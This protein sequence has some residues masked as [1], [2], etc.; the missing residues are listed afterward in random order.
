VPEP[1][2]LTNQMCGADRSLYLR[3]GPE[4]RTSANS[5]RS[6][7]DH[8]RHGCVHLQLRMISLT[9]IP[10]GARPAHG[11]SPATISGAAGLPGY[12]EPCIA[13]EENQFKRPRVRTG[14][15]YRTSG[16]RRSL[17]FAAEIGWVR[18]L[19]KAQIQTNPLRGFRSLC[20]PA[21][22]RSHHHL[23]ATE[24]RGGVS[25]ACLLT[26]LSLIAKRPTPIRLAHPRIA[27]LNSSTRIVPSN[28]SPTLD[29]LLQRSR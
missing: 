17:A 12:A 16:T 3:T 26:N 23:F 4:Y 11:H 19:V 6:I 27:T 2:S 22:R 24:R 14:S 25:R 18:E 10:S 7:P 28:L 8:R 1:P 21:G 9:R 15:E 20:R 5:R 13:C 29:R